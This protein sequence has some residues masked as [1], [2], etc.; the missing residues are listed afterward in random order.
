MVT[1]LI[2]L[3]RLMNDHQL[4]MIVVR[5]VAEYQG[6]SFVEMTNQHDGSINACVHNL[7]FNESTPQIFQHVTQ[8]SLGSILV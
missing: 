5:A 8:I 6:D 3:C 4:Y 2:D 1:L 7:L